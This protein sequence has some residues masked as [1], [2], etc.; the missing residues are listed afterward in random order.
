M[1]LT[2]IILGNYFLLECL[3]VQGTMALYR[4]RPTTRG[5]YDVLMHLF[6]PPFPAVSAFREHFQ[7]EAEKLWHC[8]HPNILPL[9]EFGSGDG[10]LYVVTALPEVPT[11]EQV[12]SNMPQTPLPISRIETMMMQ[13]CSALQYLHNQQIVHGN[14]QPSSIY[15]GEEDMV[16]LTNF[17][18]RH[19]YRV[20][21]LL[22]VRSGEGNPHYIAPEQALGMNSAACD[23]YAAGVLCYRL[24]TRRHPYDGE[25]AEEIML[26]HSGAALPSMRAWRPDLPPPVERVLH[27]ALAKRPEQ[28][29]PHV[30]EFALALHAAFAT[31]QEME[32]KEQRHIAVQAYRTPAVWPS[33]AVL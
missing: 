27:C 14:I 1:E 18:L 13:L 8:Q 12:L 28:R 17:G 2:G 15:L 20:G 16:V 4:A 10:L 30:E 22:T 24:L 11:L 33:V 9:L 29:F 21:E 7:A 23:V 25:T 31:E 3:Q 5:G 6:L 19:P 26:K 32:R